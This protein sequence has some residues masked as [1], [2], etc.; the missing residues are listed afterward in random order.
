M[1]RRFKNMSI[2]HRAGIAYGW[3]FSGED[4]VKFNEATDCKYEDDFIILDPYLGASSRQKAIFG[5]WLITNSCDG[6]AVPYLSFNEID[7]HFNQTDWIER[8]EEAGYDI[9]KLLPP[10]RF[11]VNQV[12]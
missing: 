8:F 10:R 7:K 6:T 4:Y 9:S 11:L 1:V 5:I 12:Y 3:E 2:C